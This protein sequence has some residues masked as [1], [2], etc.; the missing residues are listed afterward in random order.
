MVVAGANCS[1]ATRATVKR[2]EP[3]RPT[4]GESERPLNGIAEAQRRV[5][6]TASLNK[7]T[8]KTKRPRYNERR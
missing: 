4:G 7:Y 5:G 1:L 8:N 3:P 6:G 2:A